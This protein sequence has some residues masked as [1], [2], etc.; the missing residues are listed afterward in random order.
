MPLCW[1]DSSA[2]EKLVEAFGGYEE[3]VEDLKEIIPALRRVV[4]M[5]RQE[6]R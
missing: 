5:V 1:M 3:K 2:Y 4:R 6:K